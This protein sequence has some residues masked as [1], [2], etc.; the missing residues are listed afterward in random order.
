M[1]YLT[2][3]TTDDYQELA[4]AAWKRLAQHYAKQ[5]VLLL[6][7][8]QISPHITE[9]EHGITATFFNSSDVLQVFCWNPR[10]ERFEFSEELTL[11]AKQPA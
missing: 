1:P 10:R 9:N 3:D 6:F 8:S 11:N 4:W 2:D 7:P 5:S